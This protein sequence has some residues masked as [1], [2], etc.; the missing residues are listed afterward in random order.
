M[1]SESLAARLNGIVEKKHLTK[2]KFYQLWDQGKLSREQ[3]QQYSRQYYFLEAS[4]PRYLSTVHQKCENLEVRK[5][6]T[7]NLFEEECEAVSHAQL[8]KMFQ[9]GIGVP[10]EEQTNAALLPETQA[11][12]SCLK[13][14]C[15]DRSVSE[16]L[17]CLFAY[18]AMLPEVSRRK[19]D[20]L[21]K[22]Y[23]VSDNDTL[24]F[25]STHMEADAKHSNV[26]M[27][28]IEGD[29]SVNQ[30]QLEQAVSDTCDAMN[31]FLDGVMKAY[32]QET[33]CCA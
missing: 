32:V 13:G 8:W 28:L 27:K 5:A 15:G 1:S 30:K 2:H 3:L 19:I 16:G 22:H 26:W 17:A 31:L 29:H 25:F 23:G 12:I 9:S 6:L 33:A 11:T 21:K 7:Q 18:E 4:F 20:G 14:L 10:S 24:A